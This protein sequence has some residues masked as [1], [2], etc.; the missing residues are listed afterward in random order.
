M[1]GDTVNTASRMES[2]CFSGRIQL[3]ASCERSL[4]HCAP[5]VYRVVERGGIV[6]KGKGRMNTFWLE[7]R[8]N[9]PPLAVGSTLLVSPTALGRYESIMST[10]SAMSHK[11]YDFTS[12]DQMNK[13]A[14]GKAGRPV[15]TV[16]TVVQIGAVDSNTALLLGTRDSP[17]RRAPPPR[18]FPGGP[19]RRRFSLSAPLPVEVSGTTDD[20]QSDRSD[21][22]SNVMEVEEDEDLAAFFDAL[23]DDLDS[24]V[25]SPDEPDVDSSKLARNPDSLG[26]AE[27][28]VESAKAPIEASLVA[29]SMTGHQNGIG[30]SDCSRNDESVS[31]HSSIPQSTRRIQTDT[32]I[33]ILRWRE[34]IAVCCNRPYKADSAAHWELA[35]QNESFPKW[36]LFLRRSALAAIL[37][38][39]LFLVSDYVYSYLNQPN[40]AAILIIRYGVA[41]PTL[42][43]FVGLSYWRPYQ[44]LWWISQLTTAS[45]ILIVG[46]SI[47]AISFVG[48][49]PGYGVLALFTVYV[50]NFS[51]VALFLRITLLFALV[52]AFSA[53]IAILN[54]S[55]G[56][57]FILFLY[58]VAFVVLESVPVI[59]VSP[60]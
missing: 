45:T 38:L 36:L 48:G 30:S 22:A 44:D 5:G 60:W 41:M 51:L 1:I 19:S 16:K 2:T 14:S 31:G 37:V 43:T 6:V 59:M 27:H 35:F 53:G 39:L 47:I 24:H 55:R 50:L 54:A 57:T 17:V 15:L 18:F 11:P 42:L 32:D 7:G 21:T 33:K 28:S 10:A 46:A 25:P 12:S 8:S 58:L 49:Q 29:L 13:P 34:T 4:A 26:N 40:Y 56:A 9:E 20:A 3:S 23:N 52:I